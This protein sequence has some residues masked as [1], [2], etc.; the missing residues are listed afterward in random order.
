MLRKILAC[1]LVG[2]LSFPH[3]VSS[4]PSL[5]TLKGVVTVEG[6]PVSGISVALVDAGNGTVHRVTSASNGAFEARLGPGDYL[7]TTENRAGLV[8]QQAPAMVSVAA[9]HLASARIDLLALPV[10]QDAP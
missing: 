8:V 7:V 2:L 4:S 10:P 9:G 5:G 1:A 3:A 6:R